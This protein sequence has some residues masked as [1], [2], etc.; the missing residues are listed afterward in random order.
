LRLNWLDWI[1][2]SSPLEYLLMNWLLFPSSSRPFAIVVTSCALL[3]AAILATPL[4]IAQQPDSAAASDNQAAAEKPSA[5]AEKFEVEKGFVSLFDGRLLTGWE[6]N[7]A[8]FRVEDGA[9]VGGTVEERIPHNYFLCTT[10]TF[11][12]FELRLQV[13][14]VGAGANGG[15]Q[16]RSRRVPNSEE[17]EGYQADVGGVGDR[18][19]WGGLYDE[20]RR[21]KFLVEADRTI[22]E[23]LVKQDDWNDYRIRCI[24]PKIELFVNGNQT[25]DYTEEDKSIPQS[26]IIGVQ[27]HSGPPA[28]VWYRNLRIKTL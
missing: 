28:E 3:A 7:G 21:R 27:I 17:V 20:S 12:D 24:G 22:I 19:V 13:K 4:A 1:F 2:Q 18:S 16:F 23:S 11:G 14:T 26:G 9:I 15:I 6:G 25:V 5:K 8:W 10:R